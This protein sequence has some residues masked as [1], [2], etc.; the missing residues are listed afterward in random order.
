MWQRFNN[1]VDSAKVYRDL[2]PDFTVRHQVNRWLRS[3][4]RALRFED[5]CQVFIPDILPERPRSRQLLAFI[6]NSFEHYSGLEFSRVR[7]EDRFIADLQ[8]PLVCWFD[9]PL[10][11]CDDFAETFGH[12]LSS[13]FDEA[14]FKTLQELVTFLSRQL[15]LGDTVAP[16]T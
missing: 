7:P 2:C 10:T 15:N 6:Y 4:R 9:W 14:E 12:D 5:W 11:F 13:L 16:T 3:R 1:W 8:F